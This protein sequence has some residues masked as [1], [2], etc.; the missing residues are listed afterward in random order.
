MR[1][2]RGKEAA[3]KKLVLFIVLG[4]ALVIGVEMATSVVSRDSVAEI[5]GSS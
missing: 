3:M 4:F 1:L 2:M 5:T